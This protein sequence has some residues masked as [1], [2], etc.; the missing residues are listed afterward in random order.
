MKLGAGRVDH[1]RGSV[2]G[3]RV[4]CHAYQARQ[5]VRSPAWTVLVQVLPLAFPKK[6]QDQKQGSKTMWKR[7]QK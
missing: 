7:Q 1:E 2:G 4:W 6:N 3:E 5:A